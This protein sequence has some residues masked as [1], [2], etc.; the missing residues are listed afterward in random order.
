VRR[1][2]RPSPSPRFHRPEVQAAAA[3][4][5]FPESVFPSPFV[6]ALEVQANDD[7][8]RASLSL[9]NCKPHE[10]CIE[11]CDPEASNTGTEHASRL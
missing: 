2:V 11:P 7:D 8:E 1:S 9:F 10:F 3:T 5:H 4:A 6:P